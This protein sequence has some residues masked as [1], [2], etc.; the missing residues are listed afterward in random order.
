MRGAGS[1]CSSG[2]H[3][4]KPDDTR[5]LDDRGPKLE[6]VPWLVVSAMI[7]ALVAV[8]LAGCFVWGA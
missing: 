6:A 7:S 2:C 8:L 1:F 5:K 4:V 3:V